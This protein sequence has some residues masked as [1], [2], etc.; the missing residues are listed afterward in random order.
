[1]DHS[2]V[3]AFVQATKSSE[4]RMTKTLR[5][6]RAITRCRRKEERFSADQGGAMKQP[7]IG[8]R[9]RPAQNL[10]EKYN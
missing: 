9:W 4:R 7:T 3:Q 8:A 6:T 5:S 10:K 1:M 2:K